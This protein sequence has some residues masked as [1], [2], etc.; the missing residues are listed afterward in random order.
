MA[1][2]VLNFDQFMS[3]KKHEYITVTAFGKQY[4]V[5]KEIPAIV[6]IMLARAGE[7]A[8]SGDIGLAMMKAGDIMFGEKAVMEMCENGASASDLGQ[9][10]RMVFSMISGQDID[11]DDMDEAEYDDTSGKTVR[12]SRSK[13]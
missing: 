12:K 3:E 4:K 5:K 8:N 10:F 13:K 11:G 6:P 7:K 1:N 9:L 2:N